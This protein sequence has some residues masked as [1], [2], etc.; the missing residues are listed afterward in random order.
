MMLWRTCGCSPFYETVFSFHSAICAEVGSL[1]RRVDLFRFLRILCTALR[2]GCPYLHPH[3]QRTG[4]P[5]LLILADTCRL[6]FSERAPCW[7]VRGDS[8]SKGSLRTGE[9]IRSSPTLCFFP[10]TLPKPFLSASP[11]FLVP[12]QS[13]ATLRY[14]GLLSGM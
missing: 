1:D 12:A 14:T 13:N 5:V 2:S 4:L 3:Q 9:L 10:G 8:S 6:L 11:S 7:Q